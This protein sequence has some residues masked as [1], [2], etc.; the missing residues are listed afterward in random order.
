M[1]K[2]YERAPRMA[3]IEHHPEM[4]L[5]LIDLGYNVNM[6]DSDGDGILHTIVTY[7][8]NP[9]NREIFFELIKRGAKLN[10]AN[11]QGETPLM[12][13]ARWDKRYPE[14]RA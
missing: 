8:D 4:V 1:I 5:P 13:L 9:A 3:I 12:K 7:T 11:H 10:H 14:F 6:E 2:G